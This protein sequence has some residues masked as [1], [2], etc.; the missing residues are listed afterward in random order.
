MMYRTSSRSTK[1]VAAVIGFLLIF[2]FLI[3][4]AA[5][6]QV[7]VIPAQEENT[8]ITHSR[9]VQGQ[10]A[11]VQSNVRGT[12]NS[13]EI[14]TQEVQ[15]GTRFESQLIFGIIPAIHQP[16]PA[17]NLEYVEEEDVNIEIEGAQ[18]QRGAASYW[19]GSLQEYT[20]DNTGWLMYTPDYRH[21]NNA[22]TT[23][24]ENG[25]VY[26][27][28]PTGEVIFRS[29]QNLINGKNINIISLDGDVSV[30]ATSQ[31]TVET[32]PVS[33]PQQRIA[34]QS[35]DSTPMRIRIPTLLTAAQWEDLLGTE[36]TSGFVNNVDDVA[37]E[38]AV[39]IYLQADTT[40]TL[41]MSRVYVTTRLSDTSIP[42]ASEE[43][44]AWDENQ[45]IIREQSRAKIDAQVRDKYNNP[46]PG[47]N[48]ESVARDD[49][50]DCIGNFESASGPGP[51]CPNTNV[52]QPGL[53]TSANEGQ[54]TFIYQAPEVDEDTSIDITV[55]FED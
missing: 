22:P 11:E 54:V 6:Y 48:V 35:P 25:V 5:Q 3:M 23:V 29:D 37:D 30:G 19:D 10:L 33:A 18:G 51:E 53:Q 44:I 46:I 17:G 55:K 36:I 42:S 28:Y 8:E 31:R 7:Q 40:Y 47:V 39:D 52:D 4:A 12:G 24:Y 43:Y 1:G 45:V 38:N 32:H 27:E 15:L 34:I 41:G 16:A 20:N 14:R 9:L 49:D 26:D 50:G 21:F 2:S 13:N